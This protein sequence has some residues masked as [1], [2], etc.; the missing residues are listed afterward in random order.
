MAFEVVEFREP[1]P[2]PGQ[3]FQGTL[4]TDLGTF[5]T[6]AEAVAVARQAWQS[7]RASST[8]DVC[9]WIV[10]VP[11]ETLARWIADIA[12]EHEQVLD[13]RTNTLVSLS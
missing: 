9:W 7:T 6:E 10:R 11:G 3:A 1:A 5:E 8:T 2:M 13:L 12:S 4:E